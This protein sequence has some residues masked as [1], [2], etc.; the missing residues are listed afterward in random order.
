[1]STVPFSLLVPLHIILRLKN[2]FKLFRIFIL[3]IDTKNFHREFYRKSI[4]VEFHI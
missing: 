3:L 1:M 4:V 2:D